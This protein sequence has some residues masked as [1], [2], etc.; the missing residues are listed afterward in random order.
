MLLAGAA[1][2]STYDP[3]TVTVTDEKDHA[4]PVE[5]T[6]T[7]TPNDIPDITPIDNQSNAE[8]ETITPLQVVASDGDGDSLTYAALNLPPGLTIN[9]TSGLISGTVGAGASAGSPYSVIVTVIDGKA[10]PVPAS[11]H[12]DDH[13]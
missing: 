13:G 1:S 10:A 4:T 6:W 9:P 3:V 8:G 2:A 7:I 12:M 5:F 11:F